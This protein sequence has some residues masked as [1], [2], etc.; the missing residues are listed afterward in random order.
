METP[1]DRQIEQPGQILTDTELLTIQRNMLISHGWLAQAVLGTGTNVVGLACGPTSPASMSVQVGTGAI[2]ALENLDSTPYGSLAADTTS[3]HQIVK[4]GLNLATQTLACPAPTTAGQSIVY[5]IEAAY[6]DFDTN[7]AVLQYFDS[8]NP[9]VALT[10]PAGDGISQNTTRQGLCVIQAKAGIA[11]TTGSQIA[12]SADSGYVGLYTV[13]VAYGAT[14]IT[15]GNISTLASAPFIPYTLPQVK[16]GFSNIEYFTSSGTFNVPSG[17]SRLKIRLWGGGGGSGSSGATGAGAPGGG[18][19]GGYSEGIF[20]V[21]AGSA[22]TVT[23]GAG[24]IAP[25]APGGAGGTGGT[26]S[27]G[28]YLSATGGIGGAGNATGSAGGG[29]SGTGGSL[30]LT[31]SQASTGN[32]GTSALGGSGG[33]A[34]FGASGTGGATGISTGGQVPGGGAGAA[35]STVSGQGYAGGAGLVIVEW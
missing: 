14:T 5:L 33:G 28:S 12:P 9:S 16:P 17:I 4:E 23:V 13:T 2:Y 24:G 10:G 22:I 20:S 8:A 15:S 32:N 21:T 34:P 31:G 19:G 26:S 27:F 30:N 3:A 1:I 25:S 18:G 7:S 29:G 6:Q 11:A 35:G